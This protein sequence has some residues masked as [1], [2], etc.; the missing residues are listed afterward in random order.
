[1]KLPINKY[2]IKDESVSHG[3]IDFQIISSLEGFQELS[4]ELR[5]KLDRIKL[6]LES[7][8]NFDYKRELLFNA[9]ATRSPGYTERNSIT[10]LIDDD[11]LKYEAKT[12]WSSSLGETI[13]LLIAIAFLVFAL[14]GVWVTVKLFVT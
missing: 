7:D 14:I 8:S 4:D 13:K 12:A 11:L 2:F 3:H 10:L 9:C 6:R 5:T 1:M